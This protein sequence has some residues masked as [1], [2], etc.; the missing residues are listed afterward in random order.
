[1]VRLRAG[2]RRVVDNRGLIAASG[3]DLAI[4]GV[5]AGVGDAAREPAA[6]NSGVRI[7]RGLGLFEPFKIGGRFGPKAQRIALPARVNFMVAA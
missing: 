1:M 5:E 6:V 3:V 2:E 7:E 4:D